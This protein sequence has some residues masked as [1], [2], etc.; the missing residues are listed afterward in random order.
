LKKKT[1]KTNEKSTNEDAVKLLAKCP[2]GEKCYRSNPDHLKQFSHPPK[3]N[4]I[5]NNNNN[6]NNNNSNKKEKIE[7]KMQK[8]KM[9]IQKIQI[10]MM[11]GKKL[12]KIKESK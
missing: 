4:I 5:N 1:K 10:L 6:N 9:K 3:D 8:L 11:N 2:Y 12:L 7:K